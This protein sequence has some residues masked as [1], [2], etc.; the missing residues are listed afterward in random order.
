MATKHFDTNLAV[1][2]KVSVTE[3][4][5]DPEDLVTLGYFDANAGGSTEGLVAGL[6][7]ATG[8][9]LGTES[10]YALIGTPSTTVAYIILA[11]P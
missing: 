9:W 7:G 11:D 10:E 6:N 5:V 1:T 8:L 4:P 3:D 2:G